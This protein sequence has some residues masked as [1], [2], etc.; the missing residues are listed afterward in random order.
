MSCS[1]LES[2]DMLSVEIMSQMTVLTSEHAMFESKNSLEAALFC[3][4]KKSLSL[5]HIKPWLF[6]E[7]LFIIQKTMLTVIKAGVKP[8]PSYNLSS[9]TS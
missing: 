8:S 3:S 9:L 1:D 2:V 7:C 6:M 5:K 4:L